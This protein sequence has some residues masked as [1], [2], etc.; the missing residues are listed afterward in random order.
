MAQVKDISID[1]GATYTLVATWKDSAGSP[2]D[3]TGYTARMQM[4]EAHNADSAL[5]SLTDGDGITIT[6][7]EGKLEI[8]I[9]AADTAGLPPGRHVYD[10]EVESAG[11]EVTRLVEGAAVVR[12][13]VTR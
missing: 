7:A 3:L 12:P 11:G 2:V 9:A 10:L 4:R 1:Q 13:E 5:L 8:S 6:A